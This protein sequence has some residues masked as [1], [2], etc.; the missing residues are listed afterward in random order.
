MYKKK[1][2]YMYKN[3][4]ITMLVAKACEPINPFGNDRKSS[5]ICPDFSLKYPKPKYLDLRTLVAP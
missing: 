3:K 5:S 2:L 4:Y 1:F